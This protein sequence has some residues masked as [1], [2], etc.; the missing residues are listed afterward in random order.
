MGGIRWASASGQSTVEFGIS[1]IVLLLLVMGLLDLSRAF[2]FSVRLQDAAREGA[3]YAITYDGSTAVTPYPYL[4]D[5][6][7]KQAVDN[8]L[9]AAGI[10]S[11]TLSNPSTTCPAT[12][13]G[14]SLYNPPYQ[15]AAYPTSAGQPL[16]YICY[17]DTAGAEP[18]FTSP[19][20]T[21]LQVIVLYRYGLVSG[22][23]Q[24]QLGFTAV[25]MAGY[26]HALVP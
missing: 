15:D 3:R 1:S 25:K 19:Q 23:L 2:Y 11:S 4:N 22:F 13:N 16:L 5:T 26:Y 6:S 12:Q 8:V 20:L 24:N 9:T 17:K 18:P 21:D 10:S 7:I 14:N